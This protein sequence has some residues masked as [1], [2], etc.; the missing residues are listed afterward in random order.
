MVPI[1]TPE[2]RPTSRRVPST[3]NPAGRYARPNAAGSSRSTSLSPASS[4]SS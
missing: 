1:S 3:A 4:R 2:G